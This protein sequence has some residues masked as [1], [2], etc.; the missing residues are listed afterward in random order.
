MIYMQYVITL[1]RWIWD[2]TQPAVQMK[3]V[4][5]STMT[6]GEPHSAA[7][8]FC[9]NMQCPANCMSYTVYLKHL[10][11]L[12]VSWLLSIYPPTVWLQSQ[13]TSFRPI[14][15]TC[16]STSAAT[17]P[18]PL[19][20]NRP[21][22]GWARQ[23]IGATLPPVSIETNRSSSAVTLAS[24]NFSLSSS[25]LW[26]GGER[27]HAHFKG[28]WRGAL[29][30]ESMGMLLKSLSVRAESLCAL[31]LRQDWVVQSS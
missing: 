4:G 29:P 11:C 20:G 10:L 16:C 28:A 1:G 31:V 27:C 5:A 12:W 8:S 19:S 13:R 22:T 3:M 30:S 7:K 24:M 17:A 18:P 14:K 26:G 2:T 6:P 25:K 15:P 23:P 9:F 21:E